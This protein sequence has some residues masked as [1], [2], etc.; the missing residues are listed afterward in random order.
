MNLFSYESKPMQILMQLGDLIILNLLYILCCLPIFT[1][2]A[3]Q[4]GLYTG[5]RTML[6]PDD[7]TYCSAAFFK[8]FKTGFGKITVA[9]CLL[10]L[11]ELVMATVAVLCLA[12]TQSNTSLPFWAAMI[13]L[14]ITALFQSLITL[15]HARFSCTPWQ[16]I[17]NA[18]FL[19]L[20]HPLR[21]LLVTALTWLPLILFLLI[22]FTEFM[23]L[24]P[25]WML[26]YFAG[27]YLFSFSVMKKPFKV[28]IDHYNETHPK[29]EEESTAAEEIAEEE[30]VEIE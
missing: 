8:G 19:A 24:T 4:A 12:Y 18:W 6:D 3:A 9:W 23:M 11:V 27:A 28:L 16:L 30:T 25:I 26:I 7:D 14:G 1:I 20:A 22:N 21:S 13:A 15:F 5:I 17:R 2:G 10:F 29:E